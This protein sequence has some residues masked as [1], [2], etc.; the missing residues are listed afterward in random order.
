MTTPMLRRLWRAAAL[1]ALL[2]I[3]PAAAAQAGSCPSATPNCVFFASENFVGP[4]YVNGQGGVEVTLSRPGAGPAGSVIV[5]ESEPGGNGWM[6]QQ[7]WGP[8]NFGPA[9][10]GKV[11]F[12]AGATSAT[13]KYYASAPRSSPIYIK[14]SDF[15]KGTPE[16]A[17]VEATQGQPPQRCKAQTAPV[18]PG[19]PSCPPPPSC[20]GDPSCPPGDEQPEDTTAPTID[21]PGFGD[22][23]AEEIEAVVA[24]KEPTSDCIGTLSIETLRRIPSPPKKAKLAR[25]AALRRLKLGQVPFTIAAG[26][27]ETLTLKFSRS[28]RRSLAYAFKRRR[29]IPVRMKIVMYDQ[30]GNSST[31]SF[32]V[33][34]KRPR[35]R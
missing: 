9:T 7:T 1:T 5:S 17:C 25:A 34:L 35:R 14:S 4:T 23:T 20:P 16:K 33:T 31:K 3:A 26:E 28:V 18:C 8:N 15:P 13:L 24:C 12:E 19:D 21:R 22:F 10:D 11:T 30:A 29:K 27:R 6:A 32:T 2:T